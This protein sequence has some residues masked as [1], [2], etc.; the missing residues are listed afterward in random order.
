[1][2]WADWKEK[3]YSYSSTSKNEAFVIYVTS[4]SQDSDIYPSWKAQI[5]LLKADETSTFI[6]PKQ[7][8]FADVFSKNLT[9]ELSEYTGINNHAI[10]LIEK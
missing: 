1:M 6:L 5:A 7:A 10:N 4:I 3:V 9:A 8:D 2:S